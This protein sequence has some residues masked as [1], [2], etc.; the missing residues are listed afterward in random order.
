VAT[1]ESQVIAAHQKFACCPV[2]L[3]LA[4]ALKRQ[5]FTAS[6]DQDQEQDQ[7]QDYD[8]ETGTREKAVVYTWSLTCGPR[9]AHVT[10]P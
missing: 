3:V 2:S 8:Q 1:P 4:L 5:L 9:A 6:G 7:D 10:K